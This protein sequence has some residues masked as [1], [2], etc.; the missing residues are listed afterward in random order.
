MSRADVVVIGLGFVGVPLAAAAARAGFQVCGVDAAAEKLS[1]LAES[2][3]AQGSQNP[4]LRTLLTTGQLEL[5]RRGA[6]PDADVY[7]ISVPTPM[8]ADG[9]IDTAHL[10]DAAEAVGKAMRKGALVLVHSTCAPGSLEQQV[11][12]L[13]ARKS[14]LLPGIDFHIAHAPERID[15]A[16]GTPTA[17][18]P[19]IVA[20]LTPQCTKAATTFLRSAFARVVPVSSIRTAEFVKTF[21]NT[22]RLVNISLANELAEVC[23]GHDVDPVEVIEAAATKPYG[24]LPHHPGIGAGGGCIPVVTEFFRASARQRGVIPPMVE[25]ALAVNA[26]MPGRTVELI[27][28]RLAR[29]WKLSLSRCK[30]LVVG[31]TYK[32]DV[33]DIRN[34]CA[35]QVINRLRVEAA[36]VGY[37]DPRIPQLRME[38][39]RA[40][41]STARLDATGFDIA[42]ILTKHTT[43]DYSALRTGALPV[44]DCSSG[45]PVPWQDHD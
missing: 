11:I 7:C 24:F 33:V 36:D 3:G 21:E 2:A 13:I 31:V 4:E 35:V 1:H 34:S 38:R 28:D 29:S 20:G 14:R 10:L 43:V 45:T 15:P 5:R 32:P 23:R 39:G 25:A 41:R 18:L 27:R 8:R 6:L 40:L 42:V 19:R 44:L 26:A 17:D 22:F 12:P 30:V 9:R 16:R 37:Y